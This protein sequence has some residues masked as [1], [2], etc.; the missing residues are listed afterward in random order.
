MECLADFYSS[1]SNNMV[2]IFITYGEAIC[3]LS[4]LSSQ[5]IRAVRNK[6]CRET[7]ESADGDLYYQGEKLLGDTTVSEAGIKE[8]DVLEF[9]AVP[10]PR[11]I[12]VSVT[13]MR[14]KGREILRIEVN[15]PAMTVGMLKAVIARD[16][17]PVECPSPNQLL[18]TYNNTEL[19]DNQTIY[20][21]NFLPDTQIRAK[22]I[23]C[24]ESPNLSYDIIATTINGQS[25]LTIEAC[26][27]KDLVINFTIADERPEEAK[28]QVILT[29][30]S[31]DEAGQAQKQIEIERI[32]STTQRKQF[33]ISY[34]THEELAPDT[35]Y[36]MR[37]QS[38][39]DRY[40]Q[41]EVHSVLTISFRTA[42]SPAQEQVPQL[43]FAW[44]LYN[45]T[46]SY[47][48]TNKLTGLGDLFRLV[49][50][51]LLKTTETKQLVQAFDETV[52][53]FLMTRQDAV[54]T[55]GMLLRIPLKWDD[56]V[57]A[58]LPAYDT[59]VLMQ[60]EDMLENSPKPKAAF[61]STSSATAVADEEVQEVDAVEEEVDFDTLSSCQEYH[62][63]RLQLQQQ[64]IQEQVALQQDLPVFADEEEM[65]ALQIS[66]EIA[67]NASPADV[68]DN[69]EEQ[70][71]GTGALVLQTLMDEL[72]ASAAAYTDDNDEI[73][74]AVIQEDEES[75]ESEG[76][77]RLVDEQ[78][79]ACWELNINGEGTIG[80]GYFT[81][82]DVESSSA[83]AAD[84][85]VN[86][87]KEEEGEVEV[88]SQAAEEE[89]DQVASEIEI[90]INDNNQEEVDEVP[91]FFDDDGEFVFVDV[92][93][94]DTQSI[95]LTDDAAHADF[96]D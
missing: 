89:E 25:L 4:V 41:D 29:I 64:Q 67:A 32:D 31:Q 93:P 86:A 20:S 80:N 92:I 23:P 46:W 16:H 90:E 14:A 28:N 76:R 84:A 78:S 17:L 43:K 10:R 88:Q 6:F 15:S 2:Y 8:D 95:L 51:Y 33:T 24:V 21:L 70:T 22:I 49:R 58:V 3:Q 12:A 60:A 82:D 37:L 44:P 94:T 63:E 26:P 27:T 87:E 47:P 69:D 18:L 7:G 48:L 39:H 61:I 56:Q 73:N 5:R 55:G 57:R 79:K 62:Q 85:A 38:F 53:G 54:L 83:A 74:V 40:A 30:Y 96:T 42:M 71:A 52:V 45:L 36:W 77:A 19:F 11:V 9:L 72:Y 91:D 65:K 34:T 1:D 50:E 81:G 59:I 35:V 66:G 75:A 13:T 68:D